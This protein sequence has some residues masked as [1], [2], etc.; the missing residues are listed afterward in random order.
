MTSETNPAVTPPPFGFLPLARRPKKPRTEGMTEIRGPYSHPMGPRGLADVLD[1]AGPYIDS[2]KFPGGSFAL[3]GEVALR[4]MIDLAHMHDV[5][6]STGGFLEWVLAKDP[7]QVPAYLREAR[8]LGFDTIEVSTGFLTIRPADVVQL[9]SEVLEAGFEAKPEVHVRPG[10]GAYLVTAGRLAESGTT[11]L[12]P[13]LDLAA[14]CLAAGATSIM[15]E[16]EAIT[17]QVDQWDLSPIPALV[18]ALGLEHLMF[19]AAD[20]AVFDWYLRHYGPDVNL[21]V[22][23]SQALLLETHRIGSWS[24]NLSWGRVVNY[25]DAER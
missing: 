14:K 17:E 8:R 2:L 5:K 16:S 15:V 10:A 22:D 6:V 4:A 24:D 1:L 23:A 9:V 21:F 20:P 7:R 19:E 25:S 3:I 18:D 11:L 13:V 12:G